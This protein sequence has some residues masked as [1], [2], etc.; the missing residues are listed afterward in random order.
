MSC[1]CL[2]IEVDENVF[3]ILPQSITITGSAQG[4]VMDLLMTQT[5][6]NTSGS[7]QEVTYAFNQS[8]DL[9]VYETIFNIDGKEIKMEIAEESEAESR[10]QEGIES[11]ATSAI[12]QKK[13]AS[14]FAFH[15]GNV[16]SGATVSIMIRFALLGQ[17]INSTILF[18]LPT[19]LIE[20]QKYYPSRKISFFNIPSLS[21]LM[22]IDINYSSPI[23]NISS[24]SIK[25]QFK[26]KKFI[27]KSIPFGNNSVIQI[28]LDPKTNSNEALI[29][30][31]YSLF[32]P[33]FN[34]QNKMNNSDYVIIVDC[35]GSMNG[36]R[37]R[38][39]QECVHCFVASLP[40][41][42]AFEIIRFGSDID[43][44]FNKLTEYNKT[45]AKQAS[46]YAK[47]MAAD[48]GGTNPSIALDYVWNKLEKR[49][50]KILQ[51]FF[52]TDG[53]INRYEYDYCIEKAGFNRR[54]TR[55][56]TLGISG[57]AD[58]KFVKELA[59]AS[60]GEFRFVTTDISE[61]VI[62]LLQLSM[63][64]PLSFVQVHV[65]NDDGSELPIEVVPFPAPIIFSEKS[66]TLFAK[67]Q[68]SIPSNLNQNS[69]EINNSF[70]ESISI[71]I[72]GKLNNE[73]FEIPITNIQNGP[74]SALKALFA[75][76]AIIDY[77][78]QIIH[79][80]VD[81][82]KFEEYKQKII[83]LSLSSGIISNYTAL[84]GVSK[85]DESELEGVM[86]CVAPPSSMF[87]NSQPQKEQ[88]QS[89]N[90]SIFSS[91]LNFFTGGKQDKSSEKQDKLSNF[92][93]NEFIS[94]QDFDGYWVNKEKIQKFA[95]KKVQVKIPDEAKSEE[96]KVETTLIALI[97]LHVY[98][99]DRK[100]A[101][102]IIEQKSLEWLN[103]VY[104]TD[105]QKII[106]DA[107]ANF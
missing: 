26:N 40:L 102:T 42:C 43:C 62:P 92:N 85:R 98:V 23:L 68:N 6:V 17:R 14:P 56:F 30:P 88:N 105:W 76:Q 101:W 34:V 50:N 69:E 63:S 97:I 46:N 13:P 48:L 25:G 104:Q 100:D 18:N 78:Y 11:G 66:G 33:I 55:I 90:F 72:T 37:I 22:N 103:L 1:G 59:K 10:Y 45:S 82:L 70:S 19:Q 53:H 77:E 65:T 20:P 28:H 9:C 83:E 38:A 79:K 80:Q 99:Q 94:F 3:I 57:E 52:M 87:I 96:I 39:A 36:N 95:G 107:V 49:P 71:L 106:A 61:N 7:P 91:I 44:L 54:E 5:Y 41:G 15:I 21:F 29:S 51:I 81:Q 64:S 35:S 2:Y 16:P 86:Y 12:L 8:I 27:S 93:L 31:E 24:S 73:D 58:E 84:V 47:N 4:I 32:S 67:T 75:N 89:S 60:G 74:A